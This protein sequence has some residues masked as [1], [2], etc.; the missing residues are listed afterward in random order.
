MKAKLGKLK[1]DLENEIFPL[2]VASK[3]F[4]VTSKDKLYDDKIASYEKTRAS[5]AKDLHKEQ[6]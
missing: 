4:P 1:T 5:I 3:I 6:L 2:P